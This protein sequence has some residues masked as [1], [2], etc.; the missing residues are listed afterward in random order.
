MLFTRAIDD[1]LCPVPT[2]VMRNNHGGNE[3][4]AIL[5]VGFTF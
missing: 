3:I 5:G 1:V 2:M 4:R